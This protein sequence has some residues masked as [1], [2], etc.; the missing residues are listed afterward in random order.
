MAKRK[1]GHITEVKVTLDNYNYLMNGV[2]GIGKTTT[3]AEIG[4]KEFG[5]DGFLL[6]TIGREPKPNHIGGLWNEVVKDWDDLEEI[7]EILC[8]NDDGEYNNLRMV[9]IDSVDEIFRLAEEKVI[10]LHNKKVTNPSDK[11]DTI[12]RAFGGFQ[13]G[14]NKVISLVTQTL[15]KLNDRGVYLFC[16]GHTKQKNKTDQLTEIEYEQITS[17]LD[18]KYYNCIKDK[19]NIVMCAY[20]E[21]EFTDLK[22]RKDAFSKTNKDV[23]SI[24]KEERVVSFRDESYAIDV[25]SHLKYIVPKCKLD[26]DDIIKELKD[27]MRKQAGIFEENISD[28]KIKEK[29]IKEKKEKEELI[30][31]NSL[32]LKQ[33]EAIIGEIKNSLSKIE[34]E[35]LQEIMK[36]YGFSNFNDAS[37]IPDEALKE[38][39]EL[40]K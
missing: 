16:I 26:S 10:E 30:E 37:I 40:I 33:K 38:I 32:S 11:I 14:E 28:D 34:M 18:N 7:I 20:M 3:V 22:T 24:A 5:S 19:V 35:Q 8:D 25:K 12:K 36:K 13:A 2:A 39:Q 21:R 9:G 27:A 6:L 17:N 4:Q 29:V 23:G 15:F 1:I 31:N